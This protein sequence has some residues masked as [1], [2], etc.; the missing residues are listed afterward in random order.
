MV[1]AYPLAQVHTLHKYN[2]NTPSFPIFF[3]VIIRDL[4]DD[5]NLVEPLTLD[6]RIA[7][8]NYCY[9][10]ARYPDGIFKRRLM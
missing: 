2:F 1:F 4:D 3:R 9:R 8:W 6:E 10:N 5:G 7:H